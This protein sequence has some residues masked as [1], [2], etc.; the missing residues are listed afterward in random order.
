[1]RV[2]LFEV[3]QDTGDETFSR[4][5]WLHE[6]CP[7]VVESAEVGEEIDVAGDVMVGGRAE[8]LVRIA[9]CQ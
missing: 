1:M 4:R 3:D 8:P 9:A 6:L 7:D 5:A 2:V